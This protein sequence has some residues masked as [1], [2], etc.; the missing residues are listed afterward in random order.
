MY[1]TTT[2]NLKDVR[3]TRRK[4]ASSQI[5]TK[6]GLNIYNIIKFYTKDL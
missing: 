3:E 4:D 5:L 6:Y 2:A 1:H